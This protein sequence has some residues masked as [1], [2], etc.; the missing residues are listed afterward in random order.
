[1]RSMK[2]FHRR[3]RSLSHSHWNSIKL[4]ISFV[5]KTLIKV[6]FESVSEIPPSREWNTERERSGW[7]VYPKLSSLLCCC[8]IQDGRKRNY[9]QIMSTTTAYTYDNDRRREWRREEKPIFEMNK[10]SFQLPMLLSF[11][12][13]SLLILQREGRRIYKFH[14]WEKTNLK[15]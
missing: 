11:L 10:T 3:R 4:K 2:L 8:W 13:H 9:I 7:K 12:P 5:V 1:M 14:I 15:R 6:H